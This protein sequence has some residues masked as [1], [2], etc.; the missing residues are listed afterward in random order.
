M[1]YEILILNMSRTFC[2]RKKNVIILYYS[3]TFVLPSR[4]PPPMCLT[5]VQLFLVNFFETRNP[6]L[7]FVYSTHFKRNNFCDNLISYYMICL[8]RVSIFFFIYAK[9]LISIINNPENCL[10]KQIHSSAD[11]EGGDRAATLPHNVVGEGPECSRRTPFDSNWK[12]ARNCKFFG[13]GN[14]LHVSIHL[15]ATIVHS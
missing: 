11:T 1:A 5:C 4:T 3:I 9:A 7:C 6:L 13:P 10:H 14:E 15:Y 2:S 12:R 8:Y